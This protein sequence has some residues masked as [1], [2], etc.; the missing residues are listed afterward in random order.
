LRSALTVLTA[1]HPAL[2]NKLLLNLGRH[3]SG[4]LHQT[5]DSLRQ[6]GESSGC[7]S[8]RGQSHSLEGSLRI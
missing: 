2:A 1:S 3:L 8:T 7:P 5:T 4:R 6:L